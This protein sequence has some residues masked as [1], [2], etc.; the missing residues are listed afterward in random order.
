MDLAQAAAVGFF[1]GLAAQVSRLP[2]L[3]L[4][5][6]VIE[7]LAE[8]MFLSGSAR[9][10]PH[11]AVLFDQ[12]DPVMP[13]MIAELSPGE[14]TEWV[15]AQAERITG[16]EWPDPAEL[17]PFWS[18]F[19]PRKCAAKQGFNPSATHRRFGIL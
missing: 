18:A 4:E 12:L 9:I 3:G 8:R 13:E 16:K 5:K 2:L 7:P 14:L 19:D 17:E 15:R 10:M 11:L 1:G 6:A